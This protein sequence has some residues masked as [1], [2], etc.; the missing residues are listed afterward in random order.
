MSKY[1]EINIQRSIRK[2]SNIYFGVGS[3]YLFKNHWGKSGDQD[4]LMLA[5][6]DAWEDI[7][8]NKVPPDGWK[9]FEPRLQAVLNKEFLEPPF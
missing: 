3:I 5:G 1:K 4:S 7:F 9:I 6:I 8:D 2:S